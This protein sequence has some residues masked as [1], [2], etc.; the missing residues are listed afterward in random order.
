[1]LILTKSKQRADEQIVDMTVPHGVE[2]LVEVFRGAFPRR[3]ISE[4]IVEQIADMTVP[5]K[6]EQ[7]VE[8]PKTLSRE[9]IQQRVY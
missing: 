6:E 2:E 9:N 1:M 7:L 3:R 4:R 8:V 5:Q